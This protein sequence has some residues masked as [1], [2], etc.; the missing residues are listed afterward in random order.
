[1]MVTQSSNSSI[2][3]ESTGQSDLPWHTGCWVIP[4]ASRKVGL[5]S[6]CEI[7]AG[8][9]CVWQPGQHLE[10]GRVHVFGRR[11]SVF[12]IVELGLHMSSP[13]R[14]GVAGI[15]PESPRLAT[16]SLDLC[17][18]IVSADESIIGEISCW[19]LMQFA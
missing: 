11:G 10:R 3:P 9:G 18:R 12:G 19:L 16:D 13:G 4:K 7:D 2:L 17:V 5:K 14:M 8:R 6:I 1:M 15:A